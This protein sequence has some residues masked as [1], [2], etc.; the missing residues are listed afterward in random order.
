M[1]PALGAVTKSRRFS[2]HEDNVI[3]VVKV[4]MLSSPA[5]PP[6]M[7]AHSTSP[8]RYVLPAVT[9]VGPAVVRVIFPVGLRI[10]TSGVRL[11]R[12]PPIF[13]LCEAPGDGNAVTDVAGSTT[14]VMLSH[15]VLVPG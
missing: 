12:G 1:L 9:V 4:A 10:S 2:A 8:T 3:V 7:F 15:A 11:S 5:C 13:T 14:P 6:V